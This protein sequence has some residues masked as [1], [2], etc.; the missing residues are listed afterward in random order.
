MI[1]KPIETQSNLLYLNFMPQSLEKLECHLNTI[2][3][4]NKLWKIRNTIQTIEAFQCNLSNIR[5]TG[6]FFKLLDLNIGNNYTL[7]TL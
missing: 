3:E 4:K 1:K 7:Q 6:M 5:V 2:V